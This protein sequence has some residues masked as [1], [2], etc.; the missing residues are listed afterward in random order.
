MSEINKN[1]DT[2]YIKVIYHWEPYIT[3]YMIRLL[4]FHTSI[5]DLKYL[6]FNCPLDIY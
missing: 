5:L 4:F 2:Q 1:K 6:R 3:D